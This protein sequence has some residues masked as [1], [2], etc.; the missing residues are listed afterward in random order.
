[1]AWAGGLAGW[2]V[3]LLWGS[4]VEGERGLN[5]GVSDAWRAGSIRLF[6]VFRNPQGFQE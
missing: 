1:M 3:Q 4:L 2:L 6:A 5:T